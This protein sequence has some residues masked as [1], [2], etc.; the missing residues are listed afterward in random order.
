[1][2]KL[3]QT[4]F[5]KF[6]RLLRKFFRKKVWKDKEED[7]YTNLI[8]KFRISQ[9]YHRSGWLIYPEFYSNRKW[10]K[11]YLN[12]APMITLVRIIGIN[13]MRSSINLSRKEEV[14]KE[15]E[16]WLMK[17]NKKNQL[18]V[19]L[20]NQEDKP[21]EKKEIKKKQPKELIPTVIVPTPIVQSVEDD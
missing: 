14:K 20:E 3:S 10:H 4:S 9:K 13:G 2:I 5:P 15:W 8:E 11:I 6:P 21:I 7:P 16:E 18:N 19:N 12:D 17:W 1:M